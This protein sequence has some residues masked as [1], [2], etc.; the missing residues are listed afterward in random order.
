MSIGVAVS[1][2]GHRATAWAFGSLAALVETGS[3]A[4]VVSVSSVSGGSIANGAVAA[5]GDFRAIDEPERFAAALGPTLRV[6]ATD[7]LFFPGKA[8]QRYLIATLGTAGLAAM[9]AVAL[10]AGLIAAGREPRLVAY[11]I[12]GGVAGIGIGWVLAGLVWLPRALVVAAC[13]AITALLSWGAAALTGTLHGSGLWVAIAAITIVWL[14]LGW[15]AIVLFSGRGRAIEQALAR[16]LFAHPTESRPLTLADV[17]STVNHV[18][19]ATDL[20]SGDQF[21]LAPRFLYGFREGISTTAPNTVTLAAA[22]QASA[23]LPGAFP[24]SVIPTGAFT[25][26]P[27]ITEPATPPH[28]VV[29]S[30]GGVYDNMADQWEAGLKT[31]LQKCEPL[32]AVQDPAEV[33]V[34]AN[35]SAGWTWKPFKVKGRIGRELTGLLRDQGVQYDV[36]TARRRNHL[37]REFQHNRATGSGPGG[38]IVMIDRTPKTLAQPFTAGQDDIGTRARDAVAFIDAQHSDEEWDAMATRNASVPTTLGPIGIEATLDLMEHA[39]T[40]TLVGLFVL[41]GIGSLRPFPRDLYAALF[42][43]P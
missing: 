28:R 4:E 18:V 36:S 29:V 12:A 24:P 26:A 32:R 15:A 25:R 7:G 40:S 14:G 20:E 23:A 13:A 8:T 31:R 22:I 41:H 35:A 5:A 1:G 37:I 27:S 42:V 3:N 17:A 16:G 9:G 2:G 30:D 43:S 19:C 21:Y 6:V 39:F 38:I 10:L 11:A 33:L 34:I